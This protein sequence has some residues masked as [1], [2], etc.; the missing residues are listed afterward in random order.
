MVRHSLPNLVGPSP[1]RRGVITS[2]PIRRG[3]GFPRQNQKVHLFTFWLM[4]FQGLVLMSRSFQNSQRTF[5]DFSFPQ[6][7]AE[8]DQTVSRTALFDEDMANKLDGVT[9]QDTVN[10]NYRDDICWQILIVNDAPREF[11]QLVRKPAAP[12]WRNLG[13]KKILHISDW[14][15]GTGRKPGTVYIGQNGIVTSAAQELT[16]A[17]RWYRRDREDEMVQPHHVRSCSGSMERLAISLKSA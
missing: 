10:T 12:H 3:W 11:W 4:L 2:V 16:F 14:S 5:Y 15:V 6:T 7:L 8:R 13:A 17:A 1:I 9:G